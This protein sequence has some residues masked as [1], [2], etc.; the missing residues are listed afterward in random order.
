M[1]INLK[2]P[3]FLF[4]M[5]AVLVAGSI[6]GATKAADTPTREKV[7]F[8]TVEV[9]VELQEDISTDV[10]N[11]NYVKVEGDKAL[12]FKSLDSVKTGAEVMKPDK[13][14]PERVRVVNNSPSESSAPEYVRVVVKKYWL[15]DTG[16]K[17][18]TIDPSL[19]NLNSSADWGKI[20]AESGEEVIY[21]CKKPL[22]NNESSQVIESVSF[23]KDIDKYLYYMNF[24]QTTTATETEEGTIIESTRTYGGKSFKVEMKVDAVQ[25]HEAASAMLGAWGVDAKFEGDT[26]KTIDGEA[27]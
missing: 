3:L 7:V 1:K 2:N 5:G 24:T 21:Y 6:F 22:Q 25:A 17:D 16:K 20:E 13:N 4:G 10:N 15:D 14:Y 26:L 8:K 23:G 9:G 19:I 27:L 11:P 12:V 18:T